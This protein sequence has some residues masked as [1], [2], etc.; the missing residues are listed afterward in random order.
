MLAADN[1]VA[2]PA[3][4]QLIVELRS[5]SESGLLRLVAVAAIVQQDGQ[6]YEVTLPENAIAIRGAEGKP[7]IAQKLSNKKRE[8]GRRDAARFA[9]GAIGRA[10]G[11]I[12]RPRS[13]SVA[14]K[15]GGFSRSTQ[16]NDPDLLAGVLEGGADAILDDI[17][18]RNEEAISAI[19][20][21]PD[22]LFLKAGTKVEV[23]VNSSAAVDV[24]V[25]DQPVL[26]SHQSESEQ[27]ALADSD[28]F[29]PH[30]WEPEALDFLTSEVEERQT[31]AWLDAE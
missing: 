18:E 5:L 10:A 27:F 13:E 11:L 2:L 12:N 3:K 16:N 14:S 9:I 19:E 17:D 30:F 21:R 7:L 23:F 8:I 29:S 22:V 6:Q 15:S 31:L 1:S 24:L 4:T 26:E 20:Q 25:R 28:T